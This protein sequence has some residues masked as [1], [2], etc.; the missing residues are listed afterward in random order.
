MKKLLVIVS[1]VLLVGAMSF[2]TDCPTSGTVNLTETSPVD[3]TF[4]CTATGFTLGGTTTIVEWLEPGTPASLSDVLVLA[5][6]TS[7]SFTLTFISD[8]PVPPDPPNVV[9]LTEPTP[10]TLV[11]PSTTGG[12][13][14]NLA[15]FS[16]LNDGSTI[17]D[18]ASF[19]VPEP[20]GLALLGSGLLGLGAIL[21]RRRKPA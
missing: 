15:F 13:A 8:P 12:P 7:D 14:L 1:V 9:I 3:E 4:T 5:P 21:R 2:A 17:S 6:L 19:K 11:A 18:G 16:D 20:A 10:F